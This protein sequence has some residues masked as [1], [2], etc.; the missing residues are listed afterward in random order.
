MDFAWTTSCR[1]VV[2]DAWVRAWLKY[3]NLSFSIWHAPRAYH[4]T[5]AAEPTHVSVE[6]SLCFYVRKWVLLQSMAAWS[7]FADRNTCSFYHRWSKSHH[8]KWANK[9]AISK[10]NQKEI[11]AYCLHVGYALCGQQTEK[12]RAQKTTRS[13]VYMGLQLERKRRQLTQ[14]NTP[15]LHYALTKKFYRNAT[16]CV[17][18]CTRHS[19]WARTCSEMFQHIFRH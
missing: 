18:L 15:V 2:C 5:W 8:H 13:G 6:F 12:S 1:Q 16:V 19:I 17:R 3:F 11:V 14:E 9:I 7:F 10:R 4:F